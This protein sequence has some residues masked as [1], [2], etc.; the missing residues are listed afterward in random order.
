MLVQAIGDVLSL[1]VAIAVNPLAIILMILI[2]LSDRARSNGV[3]FVVG[4][5]ASILGI[6]AAAYGLADLG[7][8][9]VQEGTSDGIDATRIVLGLALWALAVREWRRRPAAGEHRPEPKVFSKVATLSGPGALV[10]GVLTAVVSVKTPPLAL[11]AGASLGQTGVAGTSA[12]IA[13]ITFALVASIGVLAPLA[14]V[15]VLG[16]RSREP[17]IALKAWLQVNATVIG[18]VI[19]VVIGA[20]LIGNGLA[21]AGR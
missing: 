16:E 5:S 10:A 4:W 12:W 20:A 18:I 9:E 7:D 17:L 6:A 1:A 13:L 8:A 2:L 14:G 3:A 11:S 15:L 21:V 19:L